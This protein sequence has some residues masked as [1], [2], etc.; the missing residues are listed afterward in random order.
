MHIAYLWHWILFCFLFIF[1]IH[2]YL[3]C[4]LWWRLQV[5]VVLSVLSVSIVRVLCLGGVR[6]GWCPHPRQIKLMI[7]I[8]VLRVWRTLVVFVMA[9][10]ITHVCSRRLWKSRRVLRSRMAT[11]RAWKIG[12]KTGYL[13]FICRSTHPSEWVGGKTTTT[14]FHFIS[15]A[16]LNKTCR[17]LVQDAA[18]NPKS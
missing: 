1:L 4:A 18:C 7:W 8:H 10:V 5:S 13:P 3:T 6:S 9:A 2:K 12:W 17:R 14:I 16:D 11:H 15:R